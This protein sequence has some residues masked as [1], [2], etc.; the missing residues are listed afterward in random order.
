MKTPVLLIFFNRDNEVQRVIDAIRKYAPEKMYLASDG[1]RTE[2]EHQKVLRIREQVKESIDWNCQINC[3]FSDK[4]LGCQWGPIT[5][6]NWVFEGEDRCIILEDDCVPDDSFFK[7][8]EQLLERYA[9]NE[10][11]WMISGDNYLKD[12]SMFEAADYTFSLRTD[13]WGWATWKRAWEKCDF[14]LRSWPVYKK[15]KY[16]S[17]TYYMK[18]YDELEYMTGQLDN[19]YRKKDKSIWDYQWRFHM[20]INNGLC[21]VPRRNLVRNIGWGK[22]ATHT[23]SG[24]EIWEMPVNSLNIPL[25]HPS[26]VVAN[27]DFD[28]QHGELLLRNKLEALR[29]ENRIGDVMKM[30]WRHYFI[31]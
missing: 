12:D 10:N 5:A 7:Y 9:D 22:T 1:G 30:L 13:T 15:G 26:C 17:H 25:R 18:Y 27:A 20:I 19:I 2:K 16:L 29:G 6:V 28:R 14:C 31:R 8:C 24:R 11:V 4:N 21:I 23:K 3:L